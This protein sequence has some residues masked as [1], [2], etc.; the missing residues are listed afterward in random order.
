MKWQNNDCAAFK[1]TKPKAMKTLCNL[2]SFAL[3]FGSS[4]SLL[5]Q[6][7][8]SKTTITPDPSA[9]L[10]I[11]GTDGGILVPRMTQAQR[12]AIN[13]P[14]HA[15]LIFQTDQLS[16][17]YYNAGTPTL[18]DWTSLTQGCG[19]RTPIFEL[20]F[21]IT[22]PGS[23]YLAA[24]LMA[25]SATDGIVIMSDQVT[26]D[27]NGYSLNGNSQLGNHGVH[28]DGAYRDIYILNGSILGWGGDGISGDAASYTKVSQLTIHNNGED[29]LILGFY[30]SVTHT[31]SSENAFDGIEVGEYAHVSYVTTEMNA[32]DGIESL[33]S[34]V[35]DH[36]IAKGN[37]AV[38]IKTLFGGII[39][40]SLAEDNG[41]HGFLSGDAKLE[42][43]IAASNTQ[44]GFYFNGNV[45]ANKI[46]A[47]SNA[48]NGIYIGDESNITYSKADNNTMSGFEITGDGISLFDCTAVA[49]AIGY[50][51]TGSGN[52]LIRNQAHGNASHYVTAAGNMVA[53]ILTAA[54]INT[55]SNAR[56]N[57]T[58]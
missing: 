30:A 4:I 14:A 8:V 25:T 42:N 58:H 47:T 34:S 50:N 6:V 2:I 5:G 10:D 44:N 43:C 26:L 9:L 54:T 16:G 19:H 57:I 27:L 22:Q 35:L 20:P 11:S 24:T 38:G 15:L 36:C 28:I 52:L 13:Q 55:S 32:S 37:G 23:Y 48:A 53:S 56:A 40:N 1:K 45:T 7:G 39:I 17:F 21:V 49:N 41:L 51:T 18:P 31:T 29:G 33:A 46:V 12:N 3:I